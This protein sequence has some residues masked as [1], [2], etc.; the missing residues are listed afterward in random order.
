MTVQSALLMDNLCL[1]SPSRPNRFEIRGD[2]SL[3][4]MR[5]RAEDEGTYTCVTENSVGK[6]EASAVLQ[7]HGKTRMHAF[8]AFYM[9]VIAAHV[10]Y[11]SQRSEM[12]FLASCICCCSS[13]L[14]RPH[15]SHL[16]LSG[17]ISLICVKSHGRVYQL[18]CCCL[19]VSSILPSELLQCLHTQ[20]TLNPKVLT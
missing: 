15:C 1:F 11:E 10:K 2:N 12:I 13:P 5:V 18:L 9:C 3:R 16:N 6:T 7:V 17:A 4:L 20:L 8:S 14:N 19:N